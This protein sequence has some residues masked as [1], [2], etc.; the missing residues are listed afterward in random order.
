MPTDSDEEDWYERRKRIDAEERL[1][2]EGAFSSN[3]PPITRPLILARNQALALAGIP[4]YYENIYERTYR[5]IIKTLMFFN[6]FIFIY[7][8]QRQM[9]KEFVYHMHL[10]HVLYYDQQIQMK[11]SIYNIINNFKIFHL[12]LMF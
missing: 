11:L 7:L 8:D 6:I 4:I 10:I 2:R 5:Y 9:V 1:E 3:P 12:V